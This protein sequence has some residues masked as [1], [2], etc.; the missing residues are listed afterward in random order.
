MKTDRR[1]EVFPQQGVFIGLP[2]PPESA[3]RIENFRY[4]P[5]NKAWHNQLGYEKLFTNQSAFSPFPGSDQRAVDSIY[6]FQQH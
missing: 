4:D 5:K 6:M 3:N 2:S 1:L